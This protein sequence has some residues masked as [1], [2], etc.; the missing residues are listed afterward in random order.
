LDGTNQFSPSQPPQSDLHVLLFPLDTQKSSTTS[1][2]SQQS[3][4]TA[5]EWV[6]NEIASLAKRLD[7]L[8]GKGKGKHRRVIKTWFIA[9]D[10]GDFDIGDTG[11][12]TCDTNGFDLW[13]PTRLGA[14]GAL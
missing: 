14:D 4:T 3:L 11:S 7:Q 6:Q 13:M 10:R 1:L 2:R 5:A 12:A 8:F 9:A